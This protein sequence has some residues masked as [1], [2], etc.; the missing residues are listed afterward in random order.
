MYAATSKLDTGRITWQFRKAAGE[1][2]PGISLV[3]IGTELWHRHLELPSAPG[4]APDVWPAIGTA[5]PEVQQLLETVVREKC[6]CWPCLPDNEGEIPGKWRTYLPIASVYI[7][8]VWTATLFPKRALSLKFLITF[9]GIPHDH[10][11]ISF[12]LSWNKEG[13][14]SKRC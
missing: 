1:R 10:V 3:R 14:I 8:D 4:L 6:H 11:G 7:L 13:F 9:S 12:G 2:L 5:R